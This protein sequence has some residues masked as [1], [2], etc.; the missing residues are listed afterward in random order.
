MVATGSQ[1]TL[2]IEGKSIDYVEKLKPEDINNALMGM[3]EDEK[4]CAE[5]AIKTLKH[6]IQKYKK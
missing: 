3:P 2:L 5:L 6:T 4:H 1:T